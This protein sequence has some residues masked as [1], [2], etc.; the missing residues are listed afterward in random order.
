MNRMALS[1][2]RVA[3]QVSFRRFPLKEGYLIILIWN[4][5]LAQCI[6]C[7]NNLGLPFG[8][9]LNPWHLNLWHIVPSQA[10][11]KCGP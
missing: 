8:I 10:F 1:P 2:S 9:R 7:H 5:A 3:R 4:V 11:M 6:T